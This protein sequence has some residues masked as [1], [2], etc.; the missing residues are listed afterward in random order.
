MGDG[1]IIVAEIE[2]GKALPAAYEMIELAKDLS[3][4]NNAACRIVAIG[5]AA[6]HAAAE[7]AGR[8]GL[9]VT[10]VEGNALGAYN[11]ELYV[12][13]LSGMI[14]DMAPR[15]ILIS[16]T[17]HGS[18]LAP[19]LAVAAGAG[20]ISAVEGC[21]R[22]E[23]RVIFRRA[24]MGGKLVM[25]QVPATPMTV[26]TVQPGSFAFAD[27]GAH[28]PGEVTTV[29]VSV[30]PRRVHFAGRTSIAE[31]TSSITEADVIVAAGRGIRKPENLQLIRRL[32]SLF[33]KSAVGGSRSVCDAGWLEYGR[34]IGITGKTV[35][36][37]LYIACGISGASQHVSGMKDSGLIVAVNSDPQAAIFGFADF[38]VV[39]DLT[40]FI[41]VLIDEHEKAA[42][43]I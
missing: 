38:G 27:E 8:S 30:E 41:P 2:D 22:R 4:G 23:G 40:T 17:V 24:L 26:L 19:A 36:P 6:A 3:G 20:C 43:R 35:R 25:E 33:T 29:Q 5:A 39:E 32:A 13:V 11:P 7:L 42:W 37:R 34:Q 9:N 14:R 16:H 10:A 31:D 21:A 18:E 28:G 15:Y 12:G 1:I